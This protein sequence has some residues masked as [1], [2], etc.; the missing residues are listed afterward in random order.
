MPNLAIEFFNK[1]AKDRNPYLRRGK[2][3][4]LQSRHINEIK[5]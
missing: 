3:K 1:I 2:S 4:K 5:M